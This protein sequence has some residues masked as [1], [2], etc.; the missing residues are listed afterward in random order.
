M[1]LNISKKPKTYESLSRELGR[2]PLTLVATYR[3]SDLALLSLPKR[4]QVYPTLNLAKKI[5]Y[6]DSQVRLDNFNV[7]NTFQ[8]R[9]LSGK[10]ILIIGVGNIGS[11]IALRLVETGANISLFRRNK[12]N[13]NTKIAPRV[14]G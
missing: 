13:N 11:K 10:K 9:D 8:S 4:K 5:N 14:G 7:R 6:Y 3:G 1:T 12:F 2:L